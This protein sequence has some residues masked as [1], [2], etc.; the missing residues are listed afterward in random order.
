M[1]YKLFLK[2][3]EEYI[4]VD[5]ELKV[6]L[7]KLFEY[8]KIKSKTHL[9]LAGEPCNFI[10][11]IISGC[12]KSYYTDKNGKDHILSFLSPGLWASDLNSFINGL[13][14]DYSI[15]SIMKT[16]VLQI[17]RPSFEKLLANHIIMETF[18]RNILQGALTTQQTKLVNILSLTSQ[19]RYENFLKLYPSVI[20]HVSY[21]DI[22]S[23]LN[24]TP[25]HLSFLRKKMLNDEKNSFA[26]T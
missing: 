21:K 12:L 8:R 25:E 19:E 13:H 6:S 14:S 20:Q 16:E 4:K 9:Q 5:D 22:A 23:Y 2:H 7:T 15:M 26:S 18:F 1:V 11:F 10:Y 17:S 3:V 24:M